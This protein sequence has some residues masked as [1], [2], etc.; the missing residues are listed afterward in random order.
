MNR[1]DVFKI[2]LI[3]LALFLFV[4]LTDRI[5]RSQNEAESELVRKAVRDAA[6]TCYAVAGAYPENV[7]YL[8]EAVPQPVPYLGVA[9]EHF[10]DKFKKEF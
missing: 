4:R 6:I 7:E 2:L 8:R 5:S 3:A 9:L 10:R 1:R